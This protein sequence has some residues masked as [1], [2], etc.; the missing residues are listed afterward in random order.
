MS[1]TA[2]HECIVCVSDRP[3]RH[4]RQSTEFDIR[5]EV[6]VV[7]LPVKVC[8]E[9]GTIEEEEGVDPANMAFAEYRT[10]KGLLS[11]EQIRNLRKQYRLS[12]RSL[13]VLLGMSEATVN[14]YEGGG[15]QTPAH[16]TAIRACENGDFV[17][18]LLQQHG[19]KLSKWQRKRVKAALE[20]QTRPQSKLAR[21]LERLEA[22]KEPNVLNGYR[23]FDRLRYAALVVWLCR[24]LPL[25]TATSLNKLLFYADFLHFKAESV[26]LTGAAYRRV[27]HGPVPSEYG[28]LRQFMESEGFVRTKEVEYQNGH[29]GEE[30]H[31]G[32]EAGQ[33]GVTFSA[34]EAKTLDAVAS[35]LKDCT[36]SEIRKRSHQE[37]AYCETGDGELIAYDKAAELSLSVPG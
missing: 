8:E 34:R 13:A 36:P 31:P 1:E 20:G 35:A 22:P 21:A 12:Q 15:L 25:V 5:G 9:C 11:P 17:C 28:D 14:R 10:R 29:T 32:P 2:T 26:S 23:H 37:A 24:Q 7:D 30:F 16:D 27:Q 19:G 33:L 3:L 6:V 18:S 4:E